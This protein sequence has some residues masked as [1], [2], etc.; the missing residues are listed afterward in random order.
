MLRIPVGYQYIPVEELDID[1]VVYTIGRVVDVFPSVREK[2][3]IDPIIGEVEN[4]EEII[5]FAVESQAEEGEF[6][7]YEWPAHDDI[8]VLAYAEII[9]L[10]DD[11][12]LLPVE[13]KVVPIF[14]SKKKP[15]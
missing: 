6:I 10:E 9:G 13:S 12:P 3:Y 1:D 7:L 2:T 11:T 4:E 14:S 5:V 8:Q 15:M